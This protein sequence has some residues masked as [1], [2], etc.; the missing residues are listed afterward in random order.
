MTSSMT[1]LYNVEK[2]ALPETTWKEKGVERTEEEHGKNK[3]Y[4]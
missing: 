2:T 1:V 3:A 4:I